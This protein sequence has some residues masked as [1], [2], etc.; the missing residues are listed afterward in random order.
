MQPKV[1]ELYIGHVA[2]QTYGNMAYMCNMSCVILS[3]PSTFLVFKLSVEY[4][5]LLYTL[6]FKH[7]QKK[8]SKGMRSGN[9]ANYSVCLTITCPL[10]W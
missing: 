6:D 8:K 10:S 9:L 2:F 4:G 7:P 1:L 3:H 5:L